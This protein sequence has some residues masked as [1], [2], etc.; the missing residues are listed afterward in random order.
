MNFY[1]C[2]CQIMHKS[3][4]DSCSDSE[5]QNCKQKVPSVSQT[6]MSAAK[7]HFFFFPT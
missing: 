2:P 5:S 4:S 7:A 3:Q 6:F 1:F